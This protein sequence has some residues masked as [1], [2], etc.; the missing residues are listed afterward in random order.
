MREREM[1]ARGGI[2]LID[3]SVDKL[4]GRLLHD[5][6]ITTRGFLSPDDAERLI[7]DV[8]KRV[9]AM[10]NGGGFD[11]EKDI[12]SAVKS[13]LHEETKRRP[14]VFISLSRA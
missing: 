9:L 10:V 2:F 8:R 1:L 6:E 4:T 12:A 14:M 7:P 5:P 13:Y 11:S 3:L